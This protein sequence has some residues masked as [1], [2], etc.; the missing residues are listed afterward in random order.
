MAA[1]LV[2]KRLEKKYIVTDAQRDAFL[3]AVYERI[4]PDEYGR[5]TVCNIYYDTPTYRLIRASIEKPVFKEKLRLRTYGVPTDDSRAFLELKKKYRGVVYKQRV[6]VTYREAES[7]LSGGDFPE[8]SEKNQ[9][10]LREIDY[11]IHHYGGLL[12]ATAIC[13]ERDP[14]RSREDSELRF[15]FDSD[16]VFRTENLDLR[17]GSGGKRILPDGMNVMEIKCF[18]SM[19]VW[20][21]KAL[22][23]NRI[24]PVSF[25]KYGKA[26]TDNFR[27]DGNIA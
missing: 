27:F 3:D 22:D 8:V 14:Y 12:P 24:F 10:V 5:S 11:F 21:A 1:Q 15:T 26:Y 18:G 20:V 7:F 2:F 13:Y 4:M 9:R 6:A 25:S 23:E 16:I 19:P 17:K